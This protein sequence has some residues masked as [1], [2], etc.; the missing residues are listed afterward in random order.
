MEQNTTQGILL[1]TLH[2]HLY[3]INRKS[4]FF[5]PTEALPMC[6]P[7]LD[8]SQTCTTGKWGDEIPGMQAKHGRGIT[9]WDRDF[10]LFPCASR[11][12]SE[13][14]K[15]ETKR[16]IGKHWQA[17]PGETVATSLL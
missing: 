13:L 1:A 8:Q 16:N 15:Y 12:A 10:G 4:R 3:L 9:A 2:F 5:T 17:N 14:L 6:A 7:G 11:G